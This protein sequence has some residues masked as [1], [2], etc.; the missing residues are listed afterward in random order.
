MLTADKLERIM[1]L[2]DQ[3]RGEYQEKLDAR[4]SELTALQETL[5]AQRAELQATIDKQLATITEM[6]GSAT[7]GQRLEQLNRE[8]NNRA[9]KLQDENAS[10]KARVKNL[11][12]D[13]ASEREENKALKQFDPPR[14]KKNLDA[15][16][17]KLADKTRANELLQ[18]S[19]NASRAEHRE[20]QQ[21]LEAAEQE[22]EQLRSADDKAEEA[23]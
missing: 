3:L 21:K 12:K 6:S 5:E 8:L 9:E 7:S 14:M 1:E 23:A 15:S 11:Q 22:L 10:L 18:K 13:L 19:L 2:E 16:K 17:K 4:D 20:A